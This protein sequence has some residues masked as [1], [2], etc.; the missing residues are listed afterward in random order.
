MPA[1]RL[2]HG[3]RL[4]LL[5]LGGWALAHAAV[6]ADLTLLSGGAVEP[7]IEPVVAAFEAATGHRVRITFNSAPQ[8]A[9]R[10]DRADTFDVVIAP[11]RV[12]D[13]PAH[14]ARF[15]SERA[16]L[17]G[18]GLGIAVRSDAPRPAIG[19]ANAVA[20][21]VRDADRVIYNTASTG[22]ATEK[23]LAELGVD[24][25]AAAKGVRPVDG[26]AVMERLLAGSGR[27]FGFGAL[28]EIGLFRDR[29]VVLVGPLPPPL[30]RETV[31]VAALPAAPAPTEAARALLAFIATPAAQTMLR[32]A[33]ISSP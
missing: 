13:E 2:R 32:A 9:A 15:G 26:A 16:P 33:G 8:I 19:D 28:T 22:L 1:R 21:A 4:F 20:Q 23:I 25:V 17:G 29:G 24:K 27:E 6:A 30:Q 3:L 18:V 31:Y 12:L 11:L 5:S 7:G 14:R 10:M